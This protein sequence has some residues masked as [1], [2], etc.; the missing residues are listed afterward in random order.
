MVV[1][2]YNGILLSLTKEENSDTGSNLE[3]ILLGEIGPS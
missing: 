3:D 2:P 1:Y